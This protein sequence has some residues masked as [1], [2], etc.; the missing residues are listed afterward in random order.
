MYWSKY[1]R[2]YKINNDYHVI[3][4]YAWGKAIFL[5]DDLMVLL[6]QQESLDE[7][8]RLH[9]DFHKA[10][11]E[12]KMIVNNQK[13]EVVD[14]KNRITRELASDKILRLTVNPTLDCNLRCWY[15][16]EKHNKKAYMNKATM[17]SVVRFVNC[18]LT[19]NTDKV[20]L[21]F[22]GGEPLLTASVRAIP[23]AKQIGELCK[24][25]KKKL[26][27]HFT[28]NGFLLSNKIV[29]EISALNVPTTFQIA[30]DGGR[31]IHNETKTAKGIG[32]YDTILTNID[33]ALSK[34]FNIIVRCNYTSR[35]IYSF[36]YL[37]DDILELNNFDCKLLRVFLQRVWQEPASMELEKKCLAVNDYINSKGI[38]S[39]NGDSICSNTY[40]YADY[41]NSY[42]INYNGDVFKC[43]ARDFDPHN[44]IGRINQEGFIEH[45]EEKFV[46][47]N[48]FT[49]DCL[50]CSI[51]PIC[52]ICS[53]T[54][55]EN[56]FR[57]CPKNIPEA[58]KEKQIRKHFNETFANYLI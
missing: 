18:K 9:P 37:V 10:L 14:I 42:V 43:T 5:I 17:C 58:D 21:S 4:N 3:Y 30:F 8:N 26:T 13:E 51:L 56:F 1:N 19:S 6:Q 2:I 36:Q 47:E 23:L 22:F 48:R 33:Y 7:I 32:T 53:Q 52:T 12:N 55:K 25:R 15:C 49:K 45:L 24:S 11:L 34:N 54:H 35:N 29:D 50:N 57:G 28:T 20:E 31:D 16:Y 39:N 44:S 27:L 40:C 46:L 41:D 38:N